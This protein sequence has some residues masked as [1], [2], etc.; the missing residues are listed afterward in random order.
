MIKTILGVIIGMF[1]YEW[2]V[3]IVFIAF[4]KTFISKEDQRNIADEVANDTNEKVSRFKQRL[5][6]ALRDQDELKNN[7]H[8]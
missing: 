1:I 5:D 2:I 6:N 4:I 8:D 7:N 3:K